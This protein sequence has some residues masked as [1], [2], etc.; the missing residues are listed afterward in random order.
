VLNAPD[1]PVRH[2][3]VGERPEGTINEQYTFIDSREDI[4]PQLNEGRQL[5]NQN[6]TTT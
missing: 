6:Q 4:A 2:F 1:M 3:I 5:Y